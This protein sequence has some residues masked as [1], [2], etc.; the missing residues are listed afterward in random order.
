M[1]SNVHAQQEKEPLEQNNDYNRNKKDTASASSVPFVS[2]K[3]LW[4]LCLPSIH[5]AMISFNIAASHMALPAALTT[6]VTANILTEAAAASTKDSVGCT[7]TAPAPKATS[8]PPISST[9]TNASCSNIHLA[10]DYFI[11]EGFLSS[12][13][14]MLNDFETQYIGYADADSATK[15][16]TSATTTPPFPS[17]TCVCLY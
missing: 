10:A 1:L 11:T 16:K 5:H 4:P 2:I 7:E 17:M 6:H 12:I 8:S 3:P 13:R 14:L 9:G 15:D